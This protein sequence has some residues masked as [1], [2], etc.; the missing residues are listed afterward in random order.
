MESIIKWISSIS[1]DYYNYNTLYKKDN[2]TMNEI[3]TNIANKYIFNIEIGNLPFKPDFYKDIFWNVDK[4]KDLNKDIIDN[5]HIIEKNN[6]F[7]DIITKFS[8]KSRNLSFDNL[9]KREKLYLVNDNNNYKIFG[10]II[11]SLDNTDFSISSGFQYMRIYESDNKTCITF[12]TEIDSEI[13]KLFF[14]LIPFIFVK[15]F[16]NM[17]TIR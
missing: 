2:I 12:F 9:E 1:N 10:I 3:K 4:I 17:I 16:K 6:S 8:I 5:I 13:P 14:K 15:M 7:Q 11:P